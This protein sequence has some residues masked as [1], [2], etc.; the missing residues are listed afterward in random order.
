VIRSER[1]SAD[2]GYVLVVQSEERSVEWAR[3]VVDRCLHDMQQPTVIE[4]SLK[5]L[6]ER[7]LML[8][9]PGGGDDGYTFT[10]AQESAE[11]VVAFANLLQEHVFPESDG[12]WGKARPACRGHGHPTK[13]TVL[14]GE[15]WWICPNTGQRLSL[16]GAYEHPVDRRTRRKLRRR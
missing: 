4:V 5:W 6:I 3:E 14:D 13:P 2:L 7:V 15:A 16:I 12:A 9:D 11:M 1:C 8:P 10:H